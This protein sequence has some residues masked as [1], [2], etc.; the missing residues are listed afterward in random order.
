MTR[1]QIET[2][3]AVLGYDRRSLAEE[4]VTGSI[5]SVL[6]EWISGSQCARWFQPLINA[7]W[8]LRL[9]ATDLLPGSILGPAA[10]QFLRLRL[11]DPCVLRG[12][13]SSR[14]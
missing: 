12:A 6:S 4:R 3:L 14:S 1:L 11:C 10:D 9:R 2:T 7:N 8:T 5:I 13:R